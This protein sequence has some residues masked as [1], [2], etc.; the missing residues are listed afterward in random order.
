MGQKF[1]RIDADGFV[2]GFWD[3]DGTVAVPGTA[4]AIDEATYQD[5]LKNQQKRRWTGSALE[6]KRRPE[7]ISIEAL[8]QEVR[9]ELDRRIDAGANIPGS[10]QVD[11]GGNM[12]SRIAHLRQLAKDKED[13]GEAVNLKFASS[14]GNSVTIGSAA[15]AKGLQKAALSRLAELMEAAADME[16]TLAIMTDA[17]REAF[18]ATA[19]VHWPGPPV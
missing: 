6:E 19:H 14:N 9:A 8:T 3:A 16:E 17:Q 7:F 18:D 13:D 5:W 1:A 4:F 11:L 12:L 15:Q 2:S 10:G